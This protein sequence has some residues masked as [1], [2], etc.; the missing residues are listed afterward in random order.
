VSGS[1][2]I[3]DQSALKQMLLL[4]EGKTLYLISDADAQR[5]YLEEGNPTIGIGHNLNSRP[6]SDDEI[7]V[8]YVTDYEVAHAT[9]V[10]LF[11]GFPNF[12]QPRRLALLDMAFNLG[13]SRLG[14]FGKMIAA[15]NEGDWLTAARE[16]QSSWWFIQVKER[17]HRVVSML[18]TNQIHP[19]YL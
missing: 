18:Q 11:P 3:D 16:A 5:V 15:I 6:L 19:S 14:M 12:P 4:D 8:I 17:G 10:H 13:Q 2:P 9:C 7:N 1:F